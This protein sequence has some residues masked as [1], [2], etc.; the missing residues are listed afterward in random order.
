MFRLSALLHFFYFMHLIDRFLYKSDSFGRVF[1]R[2]RGK[3]NVGEY[4]IAMSMVCEGQMTE[5]DK[6]D[7]SSIND[8]LIIR[9]SYA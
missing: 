3:K 5:R 6:A 1:T 4:S 7:P 8:G 2:R 9:V